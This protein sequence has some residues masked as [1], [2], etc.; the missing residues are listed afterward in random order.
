M[1]RPDILK[2]LDEVPPAI[3]RHITSSGGQCLELLNTCLAAEEQ[4]KKL[5]S[6]SLKENTPYNCLLA[7]TD[8]R[9]IF[10]APT[11][12]AIA[13]KLSNITKA[14]YFAKRLI[15]DGGN[16][17]HHLHIEPGWGEKFESYVLLA[18]AIAVLAGN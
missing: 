10:V 1:L 18:A 3:G 17:T 2:A 15:L 7:L 12:Q 13:W 4:V 6:T 9:L 16:G 8:R 5:S 11:P 14:Q